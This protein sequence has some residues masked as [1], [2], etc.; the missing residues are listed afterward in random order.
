MTSVRWSTVSRYGPSRI[1]ENIWENVFFLDLPTYMH[2]YSI[3]NADCLRLFKPS[4]IEDLE[5]Q[6]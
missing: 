6:S 5:E 4:M 3:V 2:I 1:L